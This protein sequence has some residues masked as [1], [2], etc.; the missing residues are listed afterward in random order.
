MGTM[1]RNARI[2]SWTAALNPTRRQLGFAS[3]RRAS[4][5]GTCLVP[6]CCFHASEFA[7]RLRLELNPTPSDLFVGASAIIVAIRLPP[8]AK[9][10]PGTST[11]TS[12]FRFLEY[13]TRDFCIS[14]KPAEAQI[15]A[16]RVATKHRLTHSGKNGTGNC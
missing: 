7:V 13:R 12:K 11:E 15:V 9:I 2:V 5:A 1:R 14:D 8:L 4:R 3:G 10:R 16:G 6:I